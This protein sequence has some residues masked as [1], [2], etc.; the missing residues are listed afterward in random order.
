MLHVDAL[1]VT[2]VLIVKMR[3][4]GNWSAQRQLTSDALITQCHLSATA[5]VTRQLHTTLTN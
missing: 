3:L 2:D 4:A 1:W 5:T